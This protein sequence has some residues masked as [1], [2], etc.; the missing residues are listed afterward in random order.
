MYNVYIHNVS[1]LLEP[2][3]T[4]FP[5]AKFDYINEI[6]IYNFFKTDYFN[7]NC[8]SSK[9]KYFVFNYLVVKLG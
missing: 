9:I 5:A 6:Q 8:F 4:R 3:C 2:I 7:R 1:H